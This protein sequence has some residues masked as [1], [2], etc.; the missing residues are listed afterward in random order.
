MTFASSLSSSSSRPAPPRSA[1]PS[2]TSWARCLAGLALFWVLFKIPGW[3]PPGCPARHS[4]STTRMPLPECGCSGHLAM[5]RLVDHYL[6][7]LRLRAS[8]APAAGA[9]GRVS[10]LAGGG[11]GS[12]G[13]G[14][15]RP[16]R[17]GAA[18]AAGEHQ[19]PG[20]GLGAVEACG[21]GAE[22]CSPAAGR[23]WGVPVTVWEQP[24]NPQRE[25]R[26][27][28]ADAVRARAAHIPP[29]P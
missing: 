6:P 23:R 10:A 27:G 8:A 16:G 26:P 13:G 15:G 4:P 28:P 14:G 5:Y 2:P 17:G 18:V 21:A 29:Q 25:L 19:E 11:P 20:Q 3:A 12:G 22:A 9:A 24:G 1:S 7:G